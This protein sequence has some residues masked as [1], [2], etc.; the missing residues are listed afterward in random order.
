MDVTVTMTVNGVEKTVTTD[1][2]RSQLDVLRED[3]HLTG[4]K[5]GCGEGYCGACTVLMEGQPTHAC[6]TRVSAADGK[7][8]V[9]IEGL[10]RGG[11][12]PERVAVRIHLNED[13]TISAMSGKV[14]E[15]QWARAGLSQAA[16]EE[17]RV[18]VDRIR[19]IMADT[20]VRLRSMPMRGESLKQV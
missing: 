6:V 5:Y 16:A 3:L 2:N 9:T 7:K 8:M 13:G 4:A 20:G 1:S 15:G 12:C 10:A 11:G 18:P 19:L 14:E 17:L